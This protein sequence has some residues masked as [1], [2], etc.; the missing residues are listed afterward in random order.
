VT[1]AEPGASA[2]AERLR[3][4]GF[5][6]LVAPLLRVSPV[7][8]ADL[9]LEGV[10]ALAF[11]SANGVAAF[12]DRSPERRLPVFAVGAA[13]ASAAREV[14]FQTVASADGDV[15]ALREVILSHRPPI[16]GA[17][18]IPGPAEP[19]GDLAGGLV[20]G[21]VAA[22]SVAVYQTLAGS[23]DP[24]TAAEI[25]RL[26]AVLLHSPKAA[27]ALAAHLAGVPA[28]RLTAF[29][30]SP[31][32]AAPLAGAGLAVIHTASSPDEA[33]L[34]ETLRQALGAKGHA[35][36]APG[37]ADSDHQP[38]LL[39][40]GYWIMMAFAALCIVSAV[41][42]VQVTPRLA[43]SSHTLGSPAKER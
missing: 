20:A 39:S 2:T 24:A 38:N 10:G 8:G 15:E 14:G 19:A 25:P 18:L 23:P 17:V 33:A 36:H 5:D 40:R 41:V 35:A 43:H 4:L 37:E 11:T 27:R 21:G 42:L 29:C 7:A 28:P 13:T 22:R 3:S 16:A 1:R 26:A 9:D 12:A 34:L 32:V 31:A 6:P 30:L